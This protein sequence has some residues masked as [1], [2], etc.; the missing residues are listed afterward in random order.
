M[1]PALIY[2]LKNSGTEYM[3]DTTLSLTVTDAGT[4]TIPSGTLLVC[5]PFAQFIGLSHG[6]VYDVPAGDH[7]TKVT[8]ANIPGK[9]TVNAYLSVVFSN[10]EPVTFEQ[11]YPHRNPDEIPIP[12]AMRTDGV[13]LDSGAAAVVD[14]A[15]A[16]A[17]TAS[18]D[19][20]SFTD[21]IHTDAPDGWFN[22][23]RDH[24][25]IAQTPLPDH[26]EN[27]ILARSGYDAGFYPIVAGYD[28]NHTMV[29]LHVDFL[30]VGGHPYD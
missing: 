4:I 17:F 3:G 15:A 19:L 18:T 12:S 16:E 11:P 10:T 1:D 2:P 23:L 5:D 8:I 13:A 21:Y 22:L 7:P 29:S 6:L 27:M 14:A 20:D 26:K 30:V 24:N 9:S 28:R 25:G